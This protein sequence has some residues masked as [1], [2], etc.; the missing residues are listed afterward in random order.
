MFQASKLQSPEYPSLRSPSPNTVGFGERK[1]RGKE[2]DRWWP[3]RRCS[4]RR[5]QTRPGRSIHKLFPDLASRIAFPRF[6]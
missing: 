2:M 3:G 4:P 5:Q 1:Q 6:T